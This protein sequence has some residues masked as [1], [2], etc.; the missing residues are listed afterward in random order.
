M[1]IA[2]LGAT[3][4]I[5]KNLIYYFYRDPKYEL[6][7]FARNK[8]AVYEFIKSCNDVAVP[9]VIGFEEFI[10]GNYDAV[11]NCIGVGDPAKLKNVGDKIFRLTEYFDNLVIDYLLSHKNVAYIN[12]SSGAVYGT[13]FDSGIN[14]NSFATIDV[15][16]ITSADYYRIAKLNAEA[17]HRAMPDLC[18][19]D[20]RIFSFFSRFID[21]DSGFLLCEMVR[22][23][24]DHAI[25]HTNSVD[26][27]RDYVS[28]ND[29]FALVELCFEKMPLNCVLD[30][31]SAKPV[32]KSELIKL[33]SE[34]FGLAIQIEEEDN[35]S[36][37]GIKVSYFSKNYEARRVLTYVPAKSSIQTVQE[38]AKHLM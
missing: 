34:I 15:N 22:C 19:V 26:I 28:P 5:A 20:L 10:S 35:S 1:K 21:L 2:I 29:L 9:C 38:E 31:Y 11:I 37:T 24:K 7:L 14:R 13:A 17:K 18:I 4:H 23:V 3:S 30:V 8:K 32:R 25:F 36:P 6:S 12:F 33:F 27:I 16:N